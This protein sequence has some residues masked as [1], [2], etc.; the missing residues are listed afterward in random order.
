MRQ[1][2][3]H[4]NNI[5]SD[6]AACKIFLCSLCAFPAL[7]WKTLRRAI[8]HCHASVAITLL[9]TT[10]YIRTNGAVTVKLC[11]SGIADMQIVRG[12]IRACEGL[13]Q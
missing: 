10:V 2:M 6:A 12:Q 9:R 5:V 3:P 4:R 7:R 1:V 13:F 11:L 8:A